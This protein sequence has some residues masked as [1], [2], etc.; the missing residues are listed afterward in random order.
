[1]AGRLR[2]A[3]RRSDL[4]IR[5]GENVYPAEI[6]GVLA[7]HAQVAECV[8]VGVAHADLGQEVGAIVVA[9]GADR[10]K[11]SEELSGFVAERLAH[12]KVPSQWKIVETPLP[13]NA[14][15]KVIRTAV[16]L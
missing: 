14:T 5:G 15:G 13:R 8:V 3:S 6:E 2:R 12:F 16:S 9:P 10:D 1:M 7:E 4:I 11:L